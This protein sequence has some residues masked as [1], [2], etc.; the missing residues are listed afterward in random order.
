MVD[1]DEVSLLPIERTNRRCVLTWAL[2]RRYNL[3]FA[4]Y[5]LGISC[6][7]WLIWKAVPFAQEWDSRYAFFLQ[8]VLLNYIPGLC[9][10]CIPCLHD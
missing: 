4:L 6:E 2:C 1:V 10:G 3:F 9:H 7:C 5:P 8:G